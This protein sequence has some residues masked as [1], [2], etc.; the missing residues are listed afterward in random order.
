MSKLLS[1]TSY[2]TITFIATTAHF[3]NSKA[4][5][6]FHKKDE[7]INFTN[8]SLEQYLD[9]I[10]EGESA[11]RLNPN[12]TSLYLTLSPNTMFDHTRNGYVAFH[13]ERLHFTA[14]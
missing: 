9:T 7:I 6:L 13:S 10:P 4:I 2:T 5:V 14:R 11:R 3:L 8:S 12:P 1:T